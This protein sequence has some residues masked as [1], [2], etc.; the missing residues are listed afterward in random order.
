[1]PV[2]P[3]DVV[4]AGGGVTG[5]STAWWLMSMAPSLRVLVLEKDPS[6]TQAATALSVAS[7]RQQF[8]N[9][10]NVAISRFGIEFIRD[11]AARVGPHGGVPSLGL[12]ENGYLFLAGTKENARLMEELAVM[13]RSL[14]AATEVLPAEDLARRFPW[15]VFDDVAAGSIGSR[16]EG[17]FDNM[18]LLNGFRAAARAM[19][20]VFEHDRVVGLE[21]DKDRIES[22]MAE[23][24]GRI[25][26]GAFFCAAGTGSTEICR[27]AG[28]A[29]PVEP[30]KR[31]VFVVDAPNARHPEAPLIIDHS[32]IYLR[33][34]HGQWI[35]ATVPTTDG[36][37]DRN[38]WEP[39]HAQFEDLIW[40]KLYARSEGFDAVKVTRFWVGH[41]DYNRLDQNAIIGLWPGVENFSLA[42]GFS[43][44]GLQQAPAVGRGMAEILLTG[45]YQTLDLSQLGPER[46]LTNQPFLERA[47]V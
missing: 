7:I 20:A 2:Q 41:Y 1:M 37:C 47:V 42:T 23:K 27:M 38:D 6:Y 31:T 17:W 19:G 32:G 15:M 40:P 46:I 9:P 11:F 22:V 36:P 26:C 3:W 39:D 33:P 45:H 34:E 13:Q 18:G 35:T 12:R 14:G 8:S 25:A 43:G 10:V 4:I 24:A 44:H 5:A 30:R 29:V 16:D 21:K 28:I